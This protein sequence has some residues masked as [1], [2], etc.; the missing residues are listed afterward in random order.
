MEQDR[1]DFLHSIAGEVSKDIVR[2][3]GVARSGPLA[4]PLVSVDI[5]VYL[6]WE[7][8]VILPSKPKREDRDRLVFGIQDFSPAIYAVLA[9]RGYFDREELWNYRRLGAMLQA[10]PDFKRTPGIDAPCVGSSPELFLAAPLASSLPS[11]CDTQPRVVC[12]SL[13]SDFEDESF[14]DEA[15]R[16]A[17][18]EVSNLILVVIYGESC[19]LQ[20]THDRAERYMS[21]LA[22]LGWETSF[23]DGHNFGE[24]ES[25]FSSLNNNILSPKA[26]FVGTRNAS[27]FSFVRNANTKLQ[28]CMSIEDMDQALE[29]LEGSDDGNE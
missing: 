26:V 19:G 15:R 25:V 16:I 8:L 18:S 20:S 3:V 9:R 29:E 21:D 5:L 22:A 6:Y 10:A 12:L 14:M 4:L 28:G 7:E 1:M 13:L 23:V 27:K 24:M 11:F 2:M 17:E